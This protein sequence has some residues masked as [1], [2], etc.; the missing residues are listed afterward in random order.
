MRPCFF[1]PQPQPP[2]AGERFFKTAEWP[3]RSPECVPACT[4]APVGIATAGVHANTLAAAAASRRRQPPARSYVLHH[5]P[6]ALQLSATRCMV[7]ATG[8]RSAAWGL[9]GPVSVKTKRGTRVTF[10]AGFITLP[11]TAI[12]LWSLFHGSDQQQ[13]KRLPP[14]SSSGELD[15]SDK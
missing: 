10:V 6:P 8:L 7:S 1:Q 15:L 14:G 12:S 11:L 9:F 5:F 4:H 13:Q 2:L 3:C